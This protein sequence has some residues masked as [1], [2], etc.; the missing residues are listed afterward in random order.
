MISPISG[1]EKL[2][3]L[4]AYQKEHRRKLDRSLIQTTAFGRSHIFTNLF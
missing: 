4:K 2:D 1:Q 3:L